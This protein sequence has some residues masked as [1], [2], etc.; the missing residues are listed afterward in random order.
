M[1]HVGGVSHSYRS[2]ISGLRRLR[3]EEFKLGYTE[4]V[5]VSQLPAS[6][7]TTELLKARCFMSPYIA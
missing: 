4:T 5:T 1:L 3:Q 2:V 7:F 6:S